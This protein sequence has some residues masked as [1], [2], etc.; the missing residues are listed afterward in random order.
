MEFISKASD[1]IAALSSPVER[2]IYASNLSRELDV[3]PQII[4]ADI[5]RRNAKL[6]RTERKKDIVRQEQR[7]IGAA[8]TVN[9]QRRENLLAAKAEEMLIVILARN[10]DMLSYVTE[11]ITAEEMVTD[12]G[13]KVF[14]F[15]VD[16]LKSDPSVQTLSFSEEFTSDE[17]S[18]ISYMLNTAVLSGDMQ[19]QAD[20][21][22]KTIKNYAG[23]KIDLSAMT[24]EQLA[25]LIKKEKK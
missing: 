10:P 9:P 2:E 19:S 23:K 20:D 5:E 3:S 15:F 14:A 18:R 17:T 6:V 4:K 12:W 24:S 22:I 7:I 21:C 13:K 8:D 1:V 16:G 25:E 11:K